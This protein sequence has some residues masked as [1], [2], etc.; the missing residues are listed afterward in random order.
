PDG[1]ARTF[2]AS[3]WLV[4]FSLPLAGAL[5]VVAL[6]AH[7]LPGLR[8]PVPREATP[9]E[10]WAAHDRRAREAVRRLRWVKVAFALGMIPWLFGLGAMILSG[11]ISDDAPPRM[12]WLMAGLAFLVVLLVAM[13]VP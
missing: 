5:S 11:L 1:R 2:H 12:R 10:A 3:W 13:N 9:E 7:H 4:P 6:F 8:A